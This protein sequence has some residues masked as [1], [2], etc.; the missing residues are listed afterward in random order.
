MIEKEKIVDNISSI[1]NRYSGKEEL[2]REINKLNSHIV[3]LELDVRTANLRYEKST[4]SE[5][6]AIAAKQEAEERLKAAEVR[7]C[8][9]EHELEKR[10][11]GGPGN[12]SFT[13]VDQFGKQQAHEFLKSLSSVKYPQGSLITVHIAAGEQLK[14]LKDYSVLSERIDNE[15]IALV[16]RID[17]STGFVLFHSPDHLIN[18]LMVPPAPFKRSYWSSATS[19]DTADV[20]DSLNSQR[21]ICVLVAHAGESF[22]GY[23]LDSQEFD[24]FQVIKSSVKA[25]HAKGG[26]SQRRF[27]RL[28]D[29]DIDHHIGKVRSSLRD[30]L[31]EF[32]GNIDCLFIAG[33]LQLARQ[34]TADIPIDIEQVLS[35]SEIRIEK[36]NISDILKQL[37]TFRRYRL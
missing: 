20:A 33:D 27:E 15:T 24:S 1:F 2:E 36:H 37:F 7:L 25:K 26:F 5:K 30:L 32:K 11:A 8:T 4:V 23:S 18:E 6:K 9:L 16:D 35:S 29:E 21:S 22:V 31:E 19:F 34:I 28:R 3:E 13:R 12:I 14:S 17:S 10:T